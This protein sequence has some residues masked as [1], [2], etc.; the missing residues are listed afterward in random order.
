MHH[1]LPLPAGPKRVRVQAVAPNVGPEALGYKGAHLGSRYDS[2][3]VAPREANE[4][5]GDPAQ[6]VMDLRGLAHD[7]EDEQA[8][9]LLLLGAQT[10]ELQGIEIGDL[11]E[12]LR[13]VREMLRGQREILETLPADDRSA[14][15]SVQASILDLYDAI[16]RRG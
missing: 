2:S 12:K 1:F 9:S 7:E 14:F 3:L 5:M 6:L 4:S 8:K 16:A 10:I 15:K 13:M 11:G